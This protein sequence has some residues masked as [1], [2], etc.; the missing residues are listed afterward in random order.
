MGP[1]PRS[2]AAEANGCFM[3]RVR[4]GPNRIQGCGA[5]DAPDSGLPSDQ[6]KHASTIGEQSDAIKLDTDIPIQ[7][8]VKT[9]RS[10]HT[11][12][13]LVCFLGLRSIRSRKIAKIFGCAIVRIFSTTFYTASVELTHS[14]RPRAMTGISNATPV[15]V[16][17]RG[18]TDLAD[19]AVYAAIGRKAP[20]QE[21]PRQRPEFAPKPPFDCEREI[22]FTALSRHLQRQGHTSSPRN[23]RPTHLSPN[24]ARRGPL[25]SRLYRAEAKVRRDLADLAARF[26]EVSR[27]SSL[28]PDPLVNMDGVGVAGGPIGVYRPEDRLTP[29]ALRRAACDI[30][31]PRTGSSSLPCPRRPHELRASTIPWRRSFFGFAGPVDGAHG[32][33]TRQRHHLFRRSTQKRAARKP[34]SVPSP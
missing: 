29:P 30:T 22:A 34:P 4:R 9:P 20:I 21:L 11:L 2:L 8:C 32:E 6:S 33:L 1:P 25:P 31:S 18:K 13:V 10:F 17:C 15:S 14:A 23:N 26:E 5:R 27:L 24:C 3:V 16:R 12:V 19:R 28:Q 7:G